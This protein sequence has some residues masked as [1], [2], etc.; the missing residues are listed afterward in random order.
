MAQLVKP[1]RASRAAELKLWRSRQ[2]DE[3]G[4]L[5]FQSAFVAAVS[6]KEKP[7]GVL[8]LSVPR[9]NGKSWLSG[10]LVARSLTPGDPLFESGVE[11][12]LVSS[13][14]NQARIVLE[15]AR[16]ALGEVQGYRWRNDG[17]THLESRA[18]VRIVSSDARRALGLGANV[19]LIVADEPG[20]WSPIQ[21]RRLWDA[22]LTSLGKRRT[23]IIIVGTLSPAP[24]TGPASWWPSLVAEG[25]G[26]GRHVALLQADPAKWRDFGEVLR[27]NPVCAVNPYL[28]ETLELEHAAA[29][30]SE[31]AARTYRQ[32]RCNI[33]GD[34]V[35]ARVFSASELMTVCARPAPPRE[36]A[37]VLSIDTGGFLSWSAACAIWPNGRVELWALAGPGSSVTLT[38]AEGLFIGPSEVPPVETILSRVAD[39]PE[40]PSLVVGDPHRY[41]ELQQWA[42]SR[43]VRCALRGGRSANLVG[44]VQAARRLLLDDKAAIALGAPLLQLAAS[45]VSLTGDGRGLRKTGQGR[46]DPLRALLLCAGAAQPQAAPLGGGVHVQGPAW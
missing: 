44:D 8:A 36:G 14:T 27:V 15:F 19:R 33:P 12:I 2:P 37:P 16:Q 20:A 35:E 4:L 6:R 26:E 46:D 39:F 18:R 38:E 34:P 45:E 41:I 17:V 7:A 9:G 31:N 30:K 32:F 23:Q 28:R 40:P 43:G 42:R 5:P 3:N 21:G 22:M 1:K 10:G 11:N 29:L 13:S 24:L 25:S